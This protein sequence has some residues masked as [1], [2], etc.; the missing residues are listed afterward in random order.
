[1][2]RLRIGRTLPPA[3]APIYF[4][5]L[6][7]GLRGL[8]RGR[9]QLEQFQGEL[10]AYFDVKHCFLVSSGRAAL[11]IILRALRELHP[12]RDEVLIPAFTCY[13]VPSAIARAGLK[14]R[15]CDVNAET[16][17]FDFAQLSRILDSKNSGNG[18]R[19]KSGSH[20]TDNTSGSG[21]TN[22]MNPNRL[23]AIVPVHL[24]GLPADIDG[25]RRIV[26]DP[27]VT[28][29]EDAAQAMGAEYNGKRLGTL[30]DV[31]FFS[32]GRGKALSMV[33][34]GVILTNEEKIAG[35][36][37]PQLKDMSD[38]H[39]AELASLIHKALSLSIFSRPSFFWLP[40]SL[41]FLRLGETIYDSRFKI[42]KLS[43]FQAGLGG[44]WQ[45]KLGEFRRVRRANLKYWLPDQKAK[46]GIS[47]LSHNGTQGDL[48]RLPV[49]I[50]QSRIRKE[51]VERGREKGMGIMPGYPESINRIPE[52]RSD[53]KG[54][55]FP[56]AT[57]MA[58]SLVTLPIHS[59]V[60]SRDMARITALVS[61]I[62]KEGNWRGRNKGQ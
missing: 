21:P 15:L 26:R 20:V 31:S 6:I 34:G 42:R 46:G 32:L 5:D 17:D 18:N 55:E 23:L 4:K 33:E 45:S 24:Y 29:V 58:R 36:I 38:Y 10:K 59:M 25:I 54:Q 48:I 44:S 40:T 62:I 8:V 19:L 22:S 1:L 39:T 52:I 51:I 9:D 50:E 35:G 37:T 56:I 14:V 11:T 13:S 2:R 16:L 49:R 27:K 43:A 7:A 47:F 28:I 12:E 30:G 41:S 61:K 60:S 57:Q 53:F 3:A